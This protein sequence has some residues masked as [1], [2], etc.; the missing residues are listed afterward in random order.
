VVLVGRT[1]LLCGA[2]V[3]VLVLA[4]AASGCLSSDEDDD[5]DDK[6]KPGE[7][8][9]EDEEMELGS[10]DS[11]T[12][13]LEKGVGLTEVSGGASK[14]MEATFRYNIDQWK[15]EISYREAGGKWNLSLVQPNTDLK[16]ATG[17]RNEW[18]VSLNNEV[19]I[20]LVARI[21]VGD[22]EM[23]IGDL[24]LTDVD[25]DLGVGD[26]DLGLGSYDGGNLT[27]SVN[28]G[29]GDVT[30]RVPSGMGVRIV[31]IV[32]IGGITATGFTLV[33]AEYHSSDYDVDQPHVV[34]TAI[35]G[36]GDL[37]VIEV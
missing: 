22:T 33:G 34:V 11:V 14:L 6:I 9:T 29:V 19:A 30:V 1:K 8:V 4:T 28:S 13:Y 32:D 5:D 2:L 7:L 10:A 31:P 3:L 18:D 12:V 27:V 36:V 25:V 35:L 37:T 24:N 17:A 23:S 26:L 16:V 21:G 15:P 20:D